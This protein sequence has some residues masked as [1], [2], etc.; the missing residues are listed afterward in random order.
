MPADL[1]RRAARHAQ[2]RDEILDAAAALVTER[3]AGDLNLSELATRAG[4]GNAASLY[5]YFSSKEEILTALTQRGLRRLGAH[6]R[7]VPDDLEPTDQLIELCL[8]YLDYA[9][10]HPGERR[11]LLAASGGIA[12][13]DRAAIL[14]DE[15]V[16]RMFALVADAAGQGVV[17]VRGEHDLFA[18]LH[19]CWALAQGMAEYDALYGD[20]EREVLRGRQ[21]AVFRALV[22]GFG[23]DWTGA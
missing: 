16:R 7:S 11:L 18:I 3:G 14:P 4:F 23:L 15:F 12:P 2:T 8:A 1:D 22:K 21:R 17:V 5:R 20:P 10:E 13:A 19:A 6:M 9:R